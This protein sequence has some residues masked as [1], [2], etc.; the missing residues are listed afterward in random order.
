MISYKCLVWDYSKAGTENIK[1]LTALVKWESVF[2]RK[3]FHEQVSIFN[4]MLINK[5]SNFICDKFITIHDKDP[6]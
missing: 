6:P 5:F 1:Q 2:K 3:N 4:K